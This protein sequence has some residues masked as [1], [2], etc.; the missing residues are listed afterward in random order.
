ML[1]V[2]GSS[3]TV[4][5]A[6]T[7][8][9]PRPAQEALSAALAIKEPAARLDALEKIRAD[10]PQD[11]P[12]PVDAQ[13]LATLAN[14]FPERTD[15]IAAVFD[16]IIDR[17]PADAAP[18]VRLSQTLAPVGLVVPKRLLLDRSETLVTEALAGMSLENYVRA[19]RDL[20]KRANRSEPSQPQLENGFNS[21]RA[22]AL[23]QLAR[24]R[25]A[26]AEEDLK[27]SVKLSQTYGTA[28]PALAD[29][30]LAK[31]D[32]A[33][34]EAVYKDAI[35]NSTTPA[36]ASRASMALADFYLKRGDT[37]AAEAI[38]KDTLRTNPTYS[39]A[40]LAL[41]RME[42]K[43]GDAAQALEHYLTAATGGALPSADNTAAHSLYRKAHGSDAGFEDDLDRIY[44]DK[45]PNPVTPEP[46]ARAASPNHRVVLLEMFTGSGCGPCVSADLAM[47]AVMQRYPS[48]LIVPIA[49]HANIPLPDPMVIAGGDGRREYYKV[50]GVPTF[51]IDGALGQLGGGGRANT[52]GTYTNYIAKIDKELAVPPAAAISLSAT[53]DGDAVSVTAIVSKVAS[54]S[55]NLRLHL[56]LVERELHY[57]GE[58]GV[59]FHPMVV[60]A[61]AGDRGAGIAIKGNGTTKY[62]FNLEAIRDD[63][64]KTLA[65]ELD[66][67]RG[68]EAA[69]AARRDYAADGHALTNVDPAQLS[70]VAFVQD[71]VYLPEARPGVQDAALADSGQTPPLPATTATGRANGPP[72]ARRPAASSGLQI[73]VL[74]AA[75]TDVLFGVRKAG[76]G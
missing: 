42:D 72:V 5:G 45:F 48:T 13:I 40:L 16:R 30:Y 74:Q 11:N 55:K 33:S 59:R 46:Y 53:G 3:L 14:H 6:Q 36:A 1:L 56:L 52:P 15:A 65:A 10:F 20:A 61:A 70:V 39:M 57:M 12:A 64:T 51:N 26:Q 75:K 22:R 35:K 44:R 63:V 49:Y 18:E 50:R 2:L 68:N 60:R 29:L 34:A 24:I 76:G 8:P 43:R 58:N 69:A 54:R 67:R 17:I 47:D 31:G 38:L 23:E 32:V 73:N 19:Q 25:M 37:A 41:A 28:Q 7:P 27:A 21:A 9:A 71:G 62:T 4:A 66:K